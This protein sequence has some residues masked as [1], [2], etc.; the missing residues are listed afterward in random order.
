MG[1]REQLR[2]SDRDRQT[3]ADRL[4]AAH[5]EG[6]LDFSEYDDRLARA[7][8][9][10]TFG[11]LD[12]LFVDLPAAS[13]GEVAH[14]LPSP[15]PASQGGRRVP[16]EPSVV[17]GLPAALKILW[18]VWAGVMVI[19]LTVWLLVSIGNGGTDYFWPMWLL[20]PGGALLA[21]TAGAAA[22]RRR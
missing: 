14:L 13:G 9:S 10:V 21:V 6:R 4:R 11:D 19:N 5:D 12:K 22:V 15:V 3:A 17:A 8:S 2:A 18:T 1:E 20:V 16:A 7:Y